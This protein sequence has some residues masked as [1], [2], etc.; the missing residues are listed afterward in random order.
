MRVSN[1][2]TQDNNT[3]SANGTLDGRPDH[4][5]STDQS[6]S[7]NNAHTPTPSSLRVNGFSSSVPDSNG[8]PQTPVMS[9]SLMQARQPIN[10]AVAS[11]V[12]T[13]D[14]NVPP[15]LVKLI[16]QTVIQQFQALSNPVVQPV[17]PPQPPVTAHV[18]Q[19]DNASSFAAS[20]RTERSQVYTPPSPHRPASTVNAPGY[21]TG[22]R[23][24]FSPFQHS[25]DEEAVFSEPEPT[26]TRPQAAR[27]S[28]SDGGLTVLEKVWGTFFDE[29]GQ[30]TKRLHL[31]LHGVAQ[32][33]IE[34]Y[35]PKNSLVITTHKMQRY[36]EETTLS[37]QPEIY[38]WQHVFDD[39]S[40]SVSRL[41]REPEINIEHHL[42]QKKLGGRPD[43]PGLTANGFAAWMTLLIRAH[44]DHEFERLLQTVRKMPINNPETK[45]RLPKDLSRRLFPA[46]GDDTIAI[47]L[48]KHMT[49]H[50][51]V[52]IHPRQPSN[53]DSE[54][55]QPQSSP[56]TA[57][58]RTN[59]PAPSVE[60]ASEESDR[61][62]APPAPVRTSNTTT[63]PSGGRLRETVPR[64]PVDAVPA[65]NTGEIDG[66]DIP[67]PRP[68]ERERNPYVGRSGGGKTY[69]NTTS[70]GDERYDNVSSSTRHSS[71]TQDDLR[72]I[73]STSSARN[74]QPPPPISIHQRGNATQPDDP[75]S[76]RETG[77]ARSSTVNDDQSNPMQRTRSNSTYGA[78]VQPHRRRRSNSTYGSEAP[79]TRYHPKRSPSMTQSDFPRASAPEV[80][81]TIYPAPPNAYPNGYP[82]SP[83]PQ[84]GYDY[85]NQPYDPRDPRDPRNRDRS[86]DRDHDRRSSRNRMQSMA[87][88]ST[89]DSQGYVDEHYRQQSGYQTANGNYVQP[90]GVP[91]QY[92]PTAYRHER[93]TRDNRDPRETR[94]PRDPRDSR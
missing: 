73:K 75:G 89:A 87:G 43:V 68:L 66:S 27:K 61:S 38:P 69:E 58:G 17:Q 1:M 67:T 52:Q 57:S 45:E 22:V 46:A 33:L 92:P 24:E 80:K 65:E 20:P 86:R 94:D 55:G 26:T 4:D 19:T 78:E 37:D 72:R 81:T 10:D 42:V 44:P 35:E 93:D 62:D 15:E 47:A 50:C 23:R 85:R 56:Q 49:K 8:P 51:A 74:R 14:V 79:P 54:A 59:P 12:Q 84:S 64:P 90:A 5:Y 9:P 76:A 18:D 70:S 34:D 30:T 21:G 16:T 63:D 71:T 25:S 7:Y 36:Y 11:A 31:L 60:D 3:E 32:H 77:R 13:S 40:S 88:S 82:N 48:A 91:Y 53:A 39:N 83:L 29:E 28:S 6:Q 41:F 2:S